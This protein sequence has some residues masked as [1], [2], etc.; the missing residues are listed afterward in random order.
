MKIG[1][2]TNDGAEDKLLY[3]QQIGVQGGSIWLSAI[4]GYEAQGHADVEPLRELRDRF[5]RYDLTLNAAGLGAK[6]IKQQLLGLPGRDREI[7]NVCKTI[8]NMGEAGIPI[9]II[10]QR[11]TYWAQGPE[12]GPEQTGY[13]SLPVGRGGTRLTTFDA[14]RIRPNEAPAGQVSQAE[15]WDRILYF[16]ERIVPVAEEA[17][18]KLATHP[19]DPPLQLYR[20]VDQVLNKFSGFRR[21]TEAYPSPYNGLLLCMGTMKESGEDV[22]AGV[23]HF[24]ERNLVFYV[25]YRNVRGRVPVYQE[26]FQEEG[27]LDMVEAMRTL[28]DAGFEDWVVND[29]NPGLLD[30]TRWG[31]RSLALQVG[32]IKGVLK[33]LDIPVHR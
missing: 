3:A 21:L 26:V 4:P 8:R 22:L 15:C 20:G 25:H 13:A 33:A 19:D 24:C 12:Y 32:Y 2:R 18:V 9:L 28:R 27:E 23:R 31:H 11:I 17:R 10:D 16:Y 6:V 29:H 1:I 5:E 14:A 30:D 7:D